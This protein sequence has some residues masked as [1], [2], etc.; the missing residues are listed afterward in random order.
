M[1]IPRVSLVCG[2]LLVVSAPCHAFQA[3]APA[4]QPVAPARPAAPRDIG[5]LL[6][7]IIEKH[8]VPGMAAAIVKAWDVE[9]IGVAGVRKAGAVCCLT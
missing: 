6:Q 2:L 1:R 7:P 9:A 5:A 4:P 8:K 3:A